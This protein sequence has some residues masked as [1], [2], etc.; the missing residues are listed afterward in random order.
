MSHVAASEAC[1]TPNWCGAQSKLEIPASPFLQYHLCSKPDVTIFIDEG[2]QNGVGPAFISSECSRG[3]GIPD[4]RAVM[5]EKCDRGRSLSELIYSRNDLFSFIKAPICAFI[6]SVVRCFA[7][8]IE[9][10]I[11]SSIRS[12]NFTFTS[13][14]A[15]PNIHAPSRLRI[16]ADLI[17][18]SL[19][20]WC[21]VSAPVRSCLVAW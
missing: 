3:S 9:R 17:G 12:W 16:R 5:V 4:V 14:C 7:M 1:L 19:S 10:V 11:N 20:H 6:A 15:Q 21:T 2:E 8:L 13:I 18:L